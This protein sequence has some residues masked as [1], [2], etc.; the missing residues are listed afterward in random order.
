MHCQLTRRVTFHA[1]HRMA[2][3][4][5]SAEE[6]ARRFGAAA[7]APGHGHLYRVAVTVGGPLDPETGTVVDLGTLDRVLEEEVVR[8]FDGGHLN[9]LLPE[10]ASGRAVPGCEA[11][12]AAIWRA[13]GPRLPEATRLVRV[14]VAEDESLEADCLGP[15]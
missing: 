9:A 1:A 4:D 3:G 5:W 2:R 14:T 12:A 13:V 11:I 15:D 7:L 10:V 6:N 8:R